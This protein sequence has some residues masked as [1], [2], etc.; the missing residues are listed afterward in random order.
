[1]VT[2]ERKFTDILVSEARKIEETSAEPITDV[3]AFQKT[4][5]PGTNPR[6]FDT[7]PNP[8]MNYKIKQTTEQL[9]QLQQ[10]IIEVEQFVDKLNGLDSDSIQSRLNSAEC[11]TVFS[12]IA[13]SETKKISRIAQDLSGLAESLKG[14]LMSADTSI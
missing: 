12:P 7:P 5:E 8:E 11:D 1:M 14:H 13:R 6:T 3:Q 10:W 2:F 4:L 9:K